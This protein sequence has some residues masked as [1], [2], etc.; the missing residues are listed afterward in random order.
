M[1]IDMI[2]NKLIEV[3]TVVTNQMNLINDKYK[4]SQTLANGNSK[5]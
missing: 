1:Y 3:N 2:T 4:C 5:N